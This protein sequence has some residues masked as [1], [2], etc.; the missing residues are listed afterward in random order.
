MTKLVRTEKKKID[1]NKYE[2]KS[3]IDV[4]KEEREKN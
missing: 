3:T 1:K 4:E 2:K